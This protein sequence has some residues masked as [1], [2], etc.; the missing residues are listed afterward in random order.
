MRRPLFIS[1]V[2]GV[3]T[4]IA[5]YYCYAAIF[6]AIFIL[7]LTALFAIYKKCFKNFAVIILACICI[8]I[9]LV[10]ELFS[11]ERIKNSSFYEIKES[12]VIIEEPQS[13]GS[14]KGAVASCVSGYTL[15]KGDKVKLYFSSADLSLGDT[16]S[17]A[18]T[19]KPLDKSKYKSSYYSEEVYASGNVGELYGIDTDHSWLT[20]VPKLRKTVKDILGQYMNYENQAFVSA[21]TIGDRTDFSEDFE[22]SVRKTG[23]SHIMVVSGM[24]LIILMGGIMSLLKRIFYNKYI[25]FAISLVCVLYLSAVC[26]FTMSVIRAG[27]TYILIMAAP[28]FDRDSDSLNTLGATVALMLV[29]SPFAVFSIAFQLSVLSTFGILI[30]APFIKDAVCYRF[31]IKREIPR[32][33]VEIISVTTAATVMTAPVCVYCFEQLS[34]VALL[35]NLCLNHAVT[36]VLLL[37]AVGIIFA[38]TFGINPLSHIVL[39]LADFLS[40]LIVGLIDYVGDFKYSAIYLPKETAFLFVGLAVCVLLLKWIK[41]RENRRLRRRVW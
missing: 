15:K 38:L 27:I 11:V 4:T 13:Y 26:G 9:G 16:V 37:S 2:F 17:V 39:L 31:H 12:F 19:L 33:I 25:F 23:T 22:E 1:A 10:Y 40:S 8:C 41:T 21:L 7:L 36:A 32:K 5:V 34:L 28:L 35:V 18:V 30:T 20:F 29:F 6:A 24:H 14:T 3:I